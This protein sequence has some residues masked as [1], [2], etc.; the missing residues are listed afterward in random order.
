MKT[1]NP[2]ISTMNPEPI[3]A[4]GTPLVAKIFIILFILG[5]GGYYLYT[6]VIVKI[7]AQGPVT[8][9]YTP[10]AQKVL[11]HKGEVIEAKCKDFKNIGLYLESDITQDDFNTTLMAV[12]TIPSTSLVIPNQELTYKA[13][14]GKLLV[15][16]CQIVKDP[17]DG[18]GI[19][20]GKLK[21][22]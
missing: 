7:P 15:Y 4:S 11:F 5:I 12:A 16:K 21:K 6:K 8:Q 17:Q 9:T 18:H 22:V 19:L 2:T 20:M 3:K 1:E 14:S 13:K 10:P